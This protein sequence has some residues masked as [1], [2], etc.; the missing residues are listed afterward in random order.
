MPAF[1]LG[2]LKKDK[3]DKNDIEIIKNNIKLYLN[4]LLNEVNKGAKYDKI[5]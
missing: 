2:Q 5:Y 1:S 3:F 4:A